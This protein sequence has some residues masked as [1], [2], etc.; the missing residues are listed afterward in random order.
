MGI[1]SLL[2]VYSSVLHPFCITCIRRLTQR[3]LFFVVCLSVCLSFTAM[4]KTIILGNSRYSE[5]ILA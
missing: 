1:T 4:L 5:Q 2:S 3:D